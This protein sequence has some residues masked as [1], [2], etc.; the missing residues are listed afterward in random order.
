MFLGLLTNPSAYFLAIRQ[1][2]L[3]RGEME[4][5][6]QAHR[7]YLEKFY[8]DTLQEYEELTHETCETEK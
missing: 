4:T 5:Q 1:R 6:K 8:A 3:E 7:D 2:E